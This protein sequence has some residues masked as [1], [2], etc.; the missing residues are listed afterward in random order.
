MCYASIL[1]IL[2]GTLTALTYTYLTEIFFFF[3]VKKILLRL[4][5]KIVFSLETL[6]PVDIDR[7]NLRVMLTLYLI[8]K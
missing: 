4:H 6:N 1:S 8:P 5:W 3:Q 7:L 2:Y